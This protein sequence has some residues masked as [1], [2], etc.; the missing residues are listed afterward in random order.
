MTHTNNV[1][2]P[3]FNRPALAKHMLIGAGIG[4]LVICFFVLGVRYPDPSW[5][6]LWMLRPLIVT[7]LVGAICGACVY[8][9]DR[10]RQH[11][12]WNRAFVAA[13]SVFG[14]FIGL[15][16][17]VILGLAGTMWD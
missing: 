2:T 17:G 8:T 12:G 16:M 14:Y 3:L 10:M 6:S 7:P 13:A 11:Y 15:W 5:G 9:M 1:T 4:L